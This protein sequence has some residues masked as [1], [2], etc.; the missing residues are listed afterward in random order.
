MEK[1][2]QVPFGRVKLNTDILDNIQ[3]ELGKRYVVRVGVLGKKAERPESPE[4]NADIGMA[5]EFGVESK[6]IPPRSWLRMPLQFVM[7]DFYKE[8]GQRLLDSMTK[9]NILAAFKRVGVAAV[10]AIQDAFDS[11][12]FGNWADNTEYTVAHK[13]NKSGENTPLIDTGELRKA[14]MFEVVT[15]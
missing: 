10:T 14:V 11:K 6:R 9:K 13:K 2:V 12:G 4:S 7:P 15:K 8:E 5:H 1:I 3:K